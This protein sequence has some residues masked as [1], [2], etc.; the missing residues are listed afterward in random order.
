MRWTCT[1]RQR[2]SCSFLQRRYA[3]WVGSCRGVGTSVLVLG[4]AANILGPGQRKKKK[5]G[6]LLC[7]YFFFSIQENIPWQGCGA[8]NCWRWRIAWWEVHEMLTMAPK[9]SD[10]S[11]TIIV[12]VNKRRL[13]RY[14]PTIL[15]RLTVH[16][17][18]LQLKERAS[19]TGTQRWGGLACEADDGLVSLQSTY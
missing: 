1:D 11:P 3:R 12:D 6:V 13:K 19:A 14:K 7:M 2:A 16:G 8:G 17:L 9:D 10:Y 15:C 5:G 18:G 4:V